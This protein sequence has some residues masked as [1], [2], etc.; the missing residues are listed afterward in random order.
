MA[1]SAAVDNFHLELDN[2]SHW[3]NSVRKITGLAD[4]LYTEPSEI[5][6]FE[7]NASHHAEVKLLVREHIRAKRRKIFRHWNDLAQEYIVRQDINS[8]ASSCDLEE[9]DGSRCKDTEGKNSL[10][11][12][13]YG[14]IVGT[15][16]ED[17]GEVPVLDLGI[18]VSVVT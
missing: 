1:N 8:E 14:K 12:S 11:N 17:R 6:F 2:Y 5:P 3:S 10:L 16:I 4:A 7:S 15:N 18:P 9:N 13:N